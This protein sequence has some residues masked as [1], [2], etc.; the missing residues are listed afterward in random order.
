MSTT[1]TRMVKDPITAGM[2]RRS[3]CTLDGNFGWN[4]GKYHVALDVRNLSLESIGVIRRG[5]WFD[6]RERVTIQVDELA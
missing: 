5:W 6:I 3:E 4:T 1:G 2:V